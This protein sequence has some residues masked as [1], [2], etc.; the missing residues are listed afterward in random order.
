M[1]GGKD[2]T[3]QVIRMLELGMN[4]LCVTATTD[5][6]SDIGRRNIENLK[7][8]GVDFIEY[9]TNQVV[10]RRVN[11]LALCQVGDISWPEHVTI[12]TLP[13][14][15]AV[16]MGIKLIVWGEN[17]QNEYGGPGRGRDRQHADPAL[18]RGVRRPA[19]P[20]RQRPRGPGRHRAEAPRA[21]HVSRPTRISPASA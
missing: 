5:E 16:Q 7:S 12:F 6:L 10:R 21:V 4:P 19:R 11:K 9:T 15:L 17:P 18:A 13:V 2:S 14:R 8:L 3:T 20:A 1:S